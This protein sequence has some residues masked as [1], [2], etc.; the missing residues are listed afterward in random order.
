M[1]KQQGCSHPNFP[2]FH[3]SSF[4]QWLRWKTCPAD[5]KLKLSFYG[6]IIIIFVFF[7]TIQPVHAVTGNW[8]H[9]NAPTPTTEHAYYDWFRFGSKESAANDY[10]SQPGK[11]YRIKSLSLTRT[12]ESFESWW[13]VCELKHV[14]E[15]GTIEWIGWGGGSIR[16]E[17]PCYR[18][19]NDVPICCPYGTE[20]NPIIRKCEASCPEG[21]LFDETMSRCYIPL[22]KQCSGNPIKTL[23]GEKLQI[24]TDYLSN[25]SLMTLRRTYANVVN[26][27]RHDVFWLQPNPGLSIM[28]KVFR[29]VPFKTTEEWLN[30]FPY[31]VNNPTHIPDITPEFSFDENWRWSFEHSLIVYR[32]VLPTKVVAVRG[33][34]TEVLFTNGRSN[35][36]P[37]AQLDQLVGDPNGYAWKFVLGH[38]VEYYNDQK[39]IQ[40]IAKPSSQ[41]A[42]DFIYDTNGRLAQIIDSQS[43]VIGFTYNTSGKVSTANLPDG[44]S[45]SYDYDAGGNLETVTYPMDG[46]PAVRRYHYENS[47]FPHALTGITDENGHRVS[48]WVYDSKGRAIISEHAGGADRV[49]L[50]YARLNVK[51]YPKVTVTNPLEKDTVYYF[52]DYGDI[53]QVTKVSGMSSIHCTAANRNYSYDTNGYLISKTDWNSNVTSYIRDAQG[54]ELSRTEAVGTPEARTITTTWDTVINK[55]LIITEPE[56]VTEFAYDSNGRLLSQQQHE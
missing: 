18:Q 54:R 10:C 29:Y 39:K 23:T 2:L 24:E 14:N 13:V 42:L 47:F 22:T 36:L 9:I 6:L 50:N 8:D 1:Y 4:V 49:E 40:R 45:I 15:D 19:W 7:F 21:T 5:T 11:E 12:H 32:D 44:S 35:Y 16:Q 3:L 46:T 53:R 28:N 17:D 27:N 55:P 33:D 31:L 52:K 30:S 48:S 43:R 38:Q 26:L 20:Y 41:E 51:R 25:N 56:R 37:D 34:G